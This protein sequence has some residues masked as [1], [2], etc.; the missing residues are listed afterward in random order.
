MFIGMRVWYTKHKIK[1]KK[2]TTPKNQQHNLLLFP[3]SWFCILYFFNS[4]VLQWSKQKQLC[5]LGIIYKGF[6]TYYH[7]YFYTK[8]TQKNAKKNHPQNTPKNQQH[9]LLLLFPLFLYPSV[10]QT[11]LCSLGIIY[12]GFITYYYVYLYH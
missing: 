2:K 11:K 12:K 5:S 4:D 9:N 7:V 10:K 1:R 8:H 3:Y 6:I